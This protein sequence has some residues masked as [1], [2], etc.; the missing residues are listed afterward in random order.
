[1]TRPRTAIALLLLTASLPAAGCGTDQPK[2]PLAST[3]AAS[4]STRSANPAPGSPPRST[5]PTT[6]AGPG[7]PTATTQNPQTASPAA[8]VHAFAAA[9]ARYLDG[10]LPATALP[11][12]TT[13]VQSQAGAPIPS[14][15]RA[16]TLR[17]LYI[18]QQA[19]NSYSLAFHDQA[20]QFTAQATLTQ[21]KSRYWIVQLLP[22]DLDS[23]LRKATPAP[24]PSGSLPAAQAARAFLAVY[25]PALYG[26]AQVTAIH[27]AT[28]ILLAQLKQHPPRIPLTLARLHPTLVA[29][30]MQRAQDGWLAL[31]NVTDGQ[32]SYQL[33]L[34]VIKQ[35]GQWLVSTVTSPQ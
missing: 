23:F 31:A 19:A 20:H 2:H 8:V 3:A 10:Q 26:H 5:S 29:L 1:V 28:P 22:P 34:T 12:T 16:G 6:T 4:T 18:R 13:A 30:G 17:L 32:D 11:D 9:Y 14:T 21:L 35:H 27:A 33:N 24:P 25:L 15:A 7:S